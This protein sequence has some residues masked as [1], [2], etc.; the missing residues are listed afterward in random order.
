MNGSLLYRAQKGI[1]EAAYRIDHLPKRRADRKRQQQMGQEDK[2][3]KLT[4]KQ[5]GIISPVFFKSFVS[6]KPVLE[7]ELQSLKCMFSQTASFIT[8]ATHFKTNQG[9]SGVYPDHL[10]HL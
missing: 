5:A 6:K 10:Y 9:N 4:E 7:S 1:G 8:D 2:I 3:N